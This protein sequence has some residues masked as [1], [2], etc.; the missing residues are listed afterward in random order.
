MLV[1][2]L[3]RVTSILFHVV[4]LLVILSF[5]AKAI[6]GMLSCDWSLSNREVVLSSRTQ[7]SEELY[8]RN[9][10]SLSE[11]ASEKPWRALFSPDIPWWTS[12]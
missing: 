5:A 2:I 8:L 10:S 11:M 3:K 9:S 6:T 12:K 4:G 1:K 7:L